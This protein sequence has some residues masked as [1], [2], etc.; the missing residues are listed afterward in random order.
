MDFTLYLATA[1]TRHPSGLQL[2]QTSAWS[3]LAVWATDTNM[4]SGSST[5]YELR[6]GPL[7][8]HRPQTSTWSQVAAQA[9]HIYTVPGDIRD[10][11]HHNMASGS[12]QTMDICIA[13]SGNMGHGH[14]H[15]PQ[16][17]QDHGPMNINMAPASARSRTQKW[18]PTV[19]SWTIDINM[20]SGCSTCYP[21][22][23]DPQTSTWIQAENV[24]SYTWKMYELKSCRP[25]FSNLTLEI[26]AKVVFFSL[27]LMDVV[28]SY[29]NLV[30]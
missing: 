28:L 27:F 4:D 6:H 21:H 1:D 13:F 18:I 20:D 30:N 10:H 5:D 25:G 8:Q 14:Q 16:L 7:Q 17:Q 24:H 23:H 29:R 11:G 19:A 26:H 15:R 22:L 3:L 2:P 12:S 9:T